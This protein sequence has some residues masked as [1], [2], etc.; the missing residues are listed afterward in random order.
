MNAPAPFALGLALLACHALAKEPE[1]VPAAGGQTII[2]E[3]YDD[4][5]LKTVTRIRA[6]GSLVGIFYYTPQGVPSHLDYHDD[7][8]RVR[9]IDYYRADGTA[10]TR[11]EFDEHGKIVLIQELDTDGNVTKET[12]PK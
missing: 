11:K 4:G 7:Q 1:R 2:R 10:H 5:A 9:R 6:D 3:F 8:K 12:K